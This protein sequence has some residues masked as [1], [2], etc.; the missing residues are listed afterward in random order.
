MKQLA[1]QQAE[2][3]KLIMELMQS[4]GIAVVTTA[5]ST[6]YDNIESTETDPKIL[7]EQFN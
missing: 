3:R 2:D 7:M 5:S 1:E 4:Q 6:K